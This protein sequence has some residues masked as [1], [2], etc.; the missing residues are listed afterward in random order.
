MNKLRFAAAAVAL[1][2]AAP[3]AFATN[4]YFAHG[5]GTKSKALAGA[6]T[7]LPQDTL[8]SATNPAGNAWVG[9]SI[10]LG[11]AA[12][13]PNRGYSY[14]GAGGMPATGSYDSENDMFAIPHFGW[15]T[16]ISDSSALGISLYANGGMNT[17]YTSSAGGTNVGVFMGGTAGGEATAGVNLEQAFLNLTFSHKL[18]DNA[19]VGI[20]LIGAGQKF[21]AQGLQMFSVMNM[22][23][24]D[25][26]GGTATH[27]TDNGADYSYGGGVKVGFLAQDEHFA[28]GAAYQSRLWM[29]KFD[30]Y[31]DLFAED[32]DFDIPPVATFGLAFKGNENHT[33][34]AD[35]QY[36]WYNDVDSIANP[37]SR[38]T[39]GC[40][41]GNA[42]S[43]L[44]GSDG[45]G[46]GW[47]NMIIYKVG[48]QWKVNDDFTTRVGYSYGSQPIDNSEVMFNILAPGVQEHH[49]TA[50]FTIHPD[51][52][53]EFNFAMMYSPQSDVSGAHPLGAPGTI[54]ID[55]TQW[56]FEAGLA[57]K[58]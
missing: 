53:F 31:S 3:A 4:G 47:D 5:Y 54:Q 25:A 8:A 42:E 7:A 55:M 14:D 35:V 38:L 2:L 52:E 9:D 17:E 11:V 45:A 21:E 29:T 58:F 48:W 24:T 37:M 32:G 26:L 13:A 44:G 56:E 10:N 23:K 40:M 20:S 57:W 36:I 33:L 34:V 1:T 49:Y 18:T 28:I 15:N 22:T 12:F 51:D 46:F 19:S 39:N 41:G 30:D 16:M 27:L 50:G 6:G 43:C